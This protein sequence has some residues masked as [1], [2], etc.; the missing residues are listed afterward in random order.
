MMLYGLLVNGLICSGI[1][2]A[3]LHLM[4]A[5]WFHTSGSTLTSGTAI[6]F[7]TFK[8]PTTL[9]DFCYTYLGAFYSQIG[10]I[11]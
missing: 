4:R 9:E 8:L 1:S 3:L 6:R 2:W 7:L 5:G 11:G 10:Q